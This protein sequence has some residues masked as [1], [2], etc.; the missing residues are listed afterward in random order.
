MKKT[1]LFNKKFIMDTVRELLP[2]G[3]LFLGMMIILHA[4]AFLKR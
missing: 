2:L 1:K 4:L 3:L